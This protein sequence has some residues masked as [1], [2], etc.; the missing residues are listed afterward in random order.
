[1][2]AEGE[3]EA[4]SSLIGDWIFKGLKRKEEEEKKKADPLMLPW[5]IRSQD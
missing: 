4:V 3:M 1:M 2:V 5:R